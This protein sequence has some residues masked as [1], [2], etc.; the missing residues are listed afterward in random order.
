MMRQIIF[1]FLALI[2]VGPLAACGFTPLYANGGSGSGQ[3]S[4]DKIEGRA[5]QALRKALIQQLAVGLPGVDEPANLVVI[6]DQSVSRLTLQPDQA[7]S[8]TDIIAK[9]DYVLA[10]D[11]NAISGSVGAEATFNVPNGPFADI[12]AQIDA[13]DRA[14]TL[15]ARR[16]VDDLRMK[17]ADQ[18]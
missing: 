18:K 17:L 8:R 4:V 5:G 3:I 16:I 7:A 1:A 13:S 10:L 11:D 6:F 2:L 12:T 15:I 9:A 14:A